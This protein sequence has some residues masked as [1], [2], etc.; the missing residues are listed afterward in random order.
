[1]SPVSLTKSQALA[2]RMEKLG[3]RE[4]DLD[5]SFIRSGGKGGQNVNKVSTCV[6]LVHRPSGMM[7]KCQ[8]ER[9]QGMNRYRARV[10]LADK[11]ER[12]IL[13]EKSAEAERIAKV[14]RQKRRRSRRAKEKLLQDKRARSQT[15][16]LRSPV[17]SNSGDE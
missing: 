8:R 13:G 2:E 1:M 5:E 12:Q 3:L 4:D 9:T 10:L 6:V 16:V 17:R 14:Q 11:I 7:V 15:K